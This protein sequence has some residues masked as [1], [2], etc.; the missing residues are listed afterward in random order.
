MRRWSRSGSPRTP[1]GSSA[2]GEQADWGRRQ[3]TVLARPQTA[4]VVGVGGRTWRDDGN[5]WVPFLDE[6]VTVAYAG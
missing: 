4:I 3:L 2:E 6:V 5:Q 1:R